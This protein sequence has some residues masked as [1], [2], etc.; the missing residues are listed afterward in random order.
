MRIVLAAACVAML[1]TAGIAATYLQVTPP[2]SHRQVV[3]RI[4]SGAAL[5]FR[6]ELDVTA[7]ARHTPYFP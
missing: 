3:L 2:G 7:L 4:P 5:V 1:A 6:G